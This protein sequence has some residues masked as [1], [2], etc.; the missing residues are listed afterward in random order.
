VK[1]TVKLFARF[2]SRP[3]VLTLAIL[4]LF[5]E[6]GMRLA[7]LASLK[8]DDVDIAQQR[9]LIREGKIRKGRLSFSSQTL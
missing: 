3:M 7:E 6:S 2:V 5:L 9:V 8:L 4:L 1:T